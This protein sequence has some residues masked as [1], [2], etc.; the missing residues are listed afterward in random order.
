MTTWR[1]FTML[2][3]M[4]FVVMV[5][6]M[7]PH[8]NPP[9]ENEKNQPPPGNLIST[10]TWDNGNADIDMWVRG[11]TNDPPVGYSNKGGALWN[12]L[13]DDV[14]ETSD[15]TGLNFETAYTRGI[16]PG[17]YVI[18]IHCYRCQVQVP[19][20]VKLIVSSKV[21]LTAATVVLAMADYTI[22]FANEE[23]TMLR[24][25]LTEDGK[26]KPGSINYLYEELKSRSQ[27]NR[28]G[29]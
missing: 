18:N 24:F 13:R 28:G 23:V 1:D 20:N 7:L 25:I 16:I 29:G 15:I 6:W 2:L 5:M 9:A 26:I 14:G 4:G 27:P 19:V 21:N 17:E 12:L 8:L 10:I 3:V 22:T 11:P